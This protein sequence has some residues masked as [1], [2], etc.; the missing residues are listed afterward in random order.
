[1][2]R[3]F[4]FHMQIKEDISAQNVAESLRNYLSGLAVI[5]ALDSSGV[6]HFA[7][8]V[9]IPNSRVVAGT[10]G[11]FAIQ[12]IIVYD[13]EPAGLLDFFWDALP[14][15]S[16]FQ[17]IAGIGKVPAPDVEDPGLF[18]KYISD[19]NINRK[20]RELHKGY[21]LTVKQIREKF[22]EAAKIEGA[23]MTTH[24]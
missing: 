7:R 3:P 15:R 6:I 21:N 20:P 18:R 24:Q 13:G 1:M 4:T 23:A 5:D 16:L 22:S 8:L 2:A 19:N 9:L 14:M 17:A 12:V 10:A 11:T